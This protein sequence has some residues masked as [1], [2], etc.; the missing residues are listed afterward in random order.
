MLSACAS[1]EETQRGTIG[2][3]EGFIGGV[4]A[5]EPRAALI[6]RDVLSAGGNAADAATAVYFAL[7]VTMPS[8]ASLG[9]G[10][11]CVVRDA[12]DQTTRTLDFLARAPRQVPKGASRPSAVPGNPRG[13]F[14]LHSKF[15]RLRWEELVGP[16]ESLARFGSPVSRAFASD[17]AQVE[18][19]LLAEAPSRR[20]FGHSSG[21]RVLREGE[22]M[23]QIELAA[24]LG[25]LRR[26]GPGAFY[27]GTMTRNFIEAVADAGGALT[28]ED[29]RAYRPVWRDTIAVPFGHLTAH[30]ASPPGA[31]GGVAAEMWSMLNNDGRFEDAAE[32]ERPHLLSETA[33]RA[34]ADRGQW[35]QPD[36][37]SSVPPADLASEDRAERLMASYRAD[38][39]LPA[40]QMNPAPLERLENPYATSFVVF[41]RFGS[42][43]ACA[44]TMNNL[45]GTGRFATGTGVLLAAYP[46]GA[47]RGPTSL[48]PMIV[49]NDTV[50]R[51]YFAAA[52]SGGVAAPT[53]MVNVA[54]RTLLTESSLEAAMQAKRVHHEG[55]PDI[56]FFEQGFDDAAQKA[57]LKRGH[58]LART[59]ALGRV[60]AAHCVRGIP[61]RYAKC[62]IWAD[63]RPRGY[64]LAVSAD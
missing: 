9:G 23:T 25:R 47:G 50:E 36:G 24:V 60:N 15:G 37:S 39:H 5:D 11:V 10:G 55:V 13:F 31:A 63:I 4:A 21:K 27:G 14:A 3:V 46:A 32:D 52:S 42:G 17:L 1:E 58:R 29:L 7:S 34:F 28:A 61:E 49:V 54:A 8:S 35:V 20:I 59:P 38:R 30:F 16:A 53:S 22:T 41:D 6:G 48:G 64:G 43:V 44:L 56:T 40:A 19:A 62:S 57:L 18:R 33:M 51:M 2:F 45:F 12:Y 26:D